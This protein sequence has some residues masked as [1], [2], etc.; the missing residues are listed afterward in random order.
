MM[1]DYLMAAV[2]HRGM[3]VPKEQGIVNLHHACDFFVSNLFFSTLI[4]T[5]Y[6]FLQLFYLPLNLLSFM[7]DP[8]L[9]KV[10]NK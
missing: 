10:H 8:A 6:N 4:P 9:E 5:E 1:F 3:P 7:L 2:P